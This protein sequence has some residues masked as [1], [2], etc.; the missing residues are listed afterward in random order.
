MWLTLVM[1]ACRDA[2]KAPT[3]SSPTGGDDTS[4]PADDTAP[5][6]DTQPPA[7]PCEPGKGAGDLPDCLGFR[8]D[9]E[10]SSGATTDGEVQSG[11]FTPDDEV[12]LKGTITNVC[13]L[14]ETL[15]GTAKRDC[16]VKA[17]VV[18]L[19]DGTESFQE[20]GCGPGSEDTT[21][22]PGQSVSSTW[23]YGQMPVGTHD[24]EVCWDWSD[25]PSQTVA[26]TVET[27]P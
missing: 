23:T 17:F 4:Q 5:P 24:V 25:K 19:E 16:T 18:T 7:D 9:V 8:F 14:A 20:S 3:D 27:G 1:F 6:V 26:L 2:E 21:L 13:N 22:D 12:T 11:I 15:T 10:A